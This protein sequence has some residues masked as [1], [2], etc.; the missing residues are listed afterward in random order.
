MPGK[1]YI[2]AQNPEVSSDSKKDKDNE[3][4]T[5]NHTIDSIFPGFL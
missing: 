2:N 4:E 1:G 5:H 3:N